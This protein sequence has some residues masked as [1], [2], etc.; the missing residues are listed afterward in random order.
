MVLTMAHQ[1]NN[2]FAGTQVV[3]LVEARGT[4]SLRE[5]REPVRVEV[6][7][8]RLLAVKR[9]EV[10]WTEVDAWCKK[11][12][13]DFEPLPHQSATGN[14]EPQMGP[15]IDVARRTSQLDA[16]TLNQ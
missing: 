6:P 8:G 9:G 10:P 16:E 2:I 14:G 12:H 15:I 5:A 4:N 3:S 7:R 1:P 13:R 11:T